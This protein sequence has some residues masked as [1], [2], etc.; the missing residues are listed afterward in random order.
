ME[1][2]FIAGTKKTPEVRFDDQQSVLDIRGVSNPEDTLL[3]YGRIYSWIDAY[4]LNP[5]EKTTINV[6]LDHFNTSSSKCL[7]EIF[8]KFERVQGD[9]HKVAVNWFYE[10]DDF[11]LQDAGDNYSYMVKIPFTLIPYEFEEE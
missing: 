10:E 4:L 11:D 5:R 9:R 2:L 8:K 3:F 6:K 7:L 1:E